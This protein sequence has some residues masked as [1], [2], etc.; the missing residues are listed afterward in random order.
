MALS[1]IFRA[2]KK[3]LIDAEDSFATP[4]IHLTDTVTNE[5]IQFCM[6]P[7]QIHVKA[8]ASFR[9]YNIIERGEIKLPKGE[10]LTQIS[11]SGLL[12]NA[13]MLLYNFMRHEFW[14]QPQEIIRALN[15]WRTDGDKLQLLVT[16]TALNLPVYLKSFDTDYK[17]SLVGINYSIQFIAA[18]QLQIMTVEEADAQKENAV[19]NRNIEI[20]RR[21]AMKSRAGILFGQVNSIWEAA[22]ILTGRGGDWQ[23]LIERNGKKNP[24]DFNSGD[25]II[26]N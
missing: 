8:A 1:E 21:A 15:R 4:E 19:N 22:R 24:E 26:W 17:K 18:K 23:T 5:I 20:K 16:Q 10:Q 3:G 25:L 11:W 2:A 14:E 9:T 13:R 6:L 12:P 7:E